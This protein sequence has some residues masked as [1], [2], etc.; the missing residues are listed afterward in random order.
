M[1]N[2]LVIED[3]LPVRKILEAVLGKDNSVLSKE[4]GQEALEWLQE[5]NMPDLIICDIQMPIMS[6]EEFV[7]E[8]KASG[9][10]KDIPIIMLSGLE[11]SEERIKMLKLGTNDYIVK[12]FNPEE[13]KLKVSIYLN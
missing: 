9:Y 3:A 2:I 1:K 8:V 6:G 12:P 13:L 5:G 7:K 10:F 4:N 11:S